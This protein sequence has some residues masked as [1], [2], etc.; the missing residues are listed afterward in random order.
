MYLVLKLVYFVFYGAA[1]ILKMDRLFA[2][3][4]QINSRKIILHL[5]LFIRLLS[6]KY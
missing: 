4:K 1:A 2:F 5:F 6:K 3:V